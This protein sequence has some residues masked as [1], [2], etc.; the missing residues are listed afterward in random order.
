MDG[1]VYGQRTSREIYGAFF[2][3]FP[4]A[5]FYFFCV[6]FL[7][8][9]SLNRDLFW[10]KGKV[11]K[12]KVSFYLH[13]IPFHFKFSKKLF[14]PNCIFFNYFLAF[15]IFM[16]GKKICI[17]YSKIFEWRENWNKPMSIQRTNHTN[18]IP[19]S[20]PPVSSTVETFRSDVTIINSRAK[21]GS[22]PCLRESNDIKDNAR[23]EQGF[24]VFG[25]SKERTFWKEQHPNNNLGQF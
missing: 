3:Y 4:N 16:N 8:Y 18:N 5:I 6:D 1:T 7:I 21:S 22:P 10:F 24:T 17:F 15:S 13:C 11:W 12:N 2:A 20:T 9:F 19:C 25:R 23:T 14:P